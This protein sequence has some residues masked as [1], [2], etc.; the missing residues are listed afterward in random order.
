M[1]DLRSEVI[2]LKYKKSQEI[3]LQE[4]NQKR[5]SL[6]T[7]LVKANQLE[8][9]NSDLRL[10]IGRLKYGHHSNQNPEHLQEGKVGLNA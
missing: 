4:A 8:Q 6:T 3:A 5:E 7:V 9:E 10:E 2:R 1:Y